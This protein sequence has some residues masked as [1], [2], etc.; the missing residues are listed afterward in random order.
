MLIA[1]AESGIT[2]ATDL[3]GKTL[4]LG[5]RDAAE[6]TVLP[7]H[8]L[9]KKGVEFD[10]VKILS[11]DEEVDLK[12][13]P[14]SS[15]HHV[16]K[17]L[18]EGRG[19]AGVISERLW[20]RV[21]KA[22]P[23]TA[24]KFRLVWTTPEFSHCVFTAGPKFDEQLGERFREVMLGMSRQDPR[25]AEVMRLEGTKQWVEGSQDGFKDLVEA[26]RAEEE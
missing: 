26:L 17:A 6:A 7:K 3:T 22:D 20:Q 12:G 9:A 5:S 18:R 2:D 16:L 19:D 13:N 14:C 8:Y 15:E 10:D 1:K 23:K 21:S 4:I 24:E 11:L 25:T